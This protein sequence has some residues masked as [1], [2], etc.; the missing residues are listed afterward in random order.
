MK[1]ME[2]KEKMGKREADIQLTQDNFEVEDTEETSN[3][4]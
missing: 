3:A 1:M 2:T 4:V